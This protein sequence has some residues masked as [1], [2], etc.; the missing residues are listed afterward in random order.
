[1]AR[2]LG[3]TPNS[4]KILFLSKHKPFST[5]AADLIKSHIKDTDIIFGEREDLFPVRI[6]SKEYDY[7]ISYISPWIIPKKLLDRTKKAAI[8]F[9]PGPPEYPGIGCTNFAI[10]HHETRYG[11]T[12]HHM[13]EKVDAGKIIAVERFPIFPKDTVY[14]LTQRSYAY[15]Y[16]AFIKIFY[17]IVNGKSLPKT[18]CTWTRIPYTRRELNDL[19]R[20]R[21]DMSEDEIKRRIRATEFPGMSG[22][23]WEA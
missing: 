17:L 7:I 16:T 13:I 14:S 11:I 8:N 19:C 3:A 4:M 2:D 23:F 22:A 15:I 1:M 21:K 5:D 6:L 9:H 18:Q 12:V 20:L 10:Y